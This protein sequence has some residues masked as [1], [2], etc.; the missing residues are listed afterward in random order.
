MPSWEGDM[1]ISA[2]VELSQRGKLPPMQKKALDYM[3]ARPD[4]VFGYRDAGLIRVLG[5]NAAAAGFTLWSLHTKGLIDKEKSGG[6]VYFG[7]K[8]AIAELRKIQGL[9]ATNPFQAA[10]ENRERIREESGEIDAQQIL[11][12]IR[13]GN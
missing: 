2:V 8:A 9:N 10:R 12:D 11:D 3:D 5:G 1:K 13:E 7:S 6:K 4:E